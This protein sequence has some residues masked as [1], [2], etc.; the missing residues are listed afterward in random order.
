MNKSVTHIPCKN[1]QAP[2]S[3]LGNHHRTKTLT[4]SFCGTVM[5]SQQK[6]RALYAFTQIQQPST[7][8]RIGKEGEIQGVSF[9][10]TGHIAYQS[11]GAAWVQF[12]LYS[13]T[14]GYAQLITQDGQYLFLR[15]TYYLPER[16]LW[17]LKQD[18]SFNAHGQRFR[19]Q[20]YH[21]AET[22]YAEG[23]LTLTAKPRSRN[24]QCFA[25]QGNHWYVSIQQRDQ[26]E[27]FSGYA[28]SSQKVESL[29]T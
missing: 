12:Q 29:F 19:I 27:Y 15:K 2:L 9:V 1:C 11:R 13:P 16:N 6:F 10:L 3:V 28:M 21:F 8:L 7:P 23:N 17:T 20:H 24:K 26:V 22:V 25:N 4:C 18:D 5:D 14:H